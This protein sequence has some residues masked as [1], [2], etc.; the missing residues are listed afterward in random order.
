MKPKGLFLLPFYGTGVKETGRLSNGHK[1]G[2]LV[3]EDN[4]KNKAAE[5]NKDTVKVD[6]QATE[7]KDEGKAYKTFKTEEEY[8][9]AVKSILKQKLPSKE[10]MDAFKTWKENQKTEAEKQA[11]KENEYQN[12]LSKNKS[13]LMEN[14]ALKSGVNKDDLD[15]IIFKVSKMEGD[16]EENLQS[17]LKENPKYLASQK[18]VIEKTIDLGG[19]H[20]D[21][22]TP[23]LS[24]M[25]YEEY[26]A[27]RKNK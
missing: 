26:K 3:M 21:T 19:E 23:D 6:T 1:A 16:F 27:Y 17:F 14:Q 10:E 9:N 8:N 11:E 25:S 4:E 5:E 24:K 15:Y 13:L 18:E 12:T 2:G 20:Q 22:Q 7:N